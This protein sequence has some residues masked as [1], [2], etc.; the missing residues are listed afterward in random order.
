MQYNNNKLLTIIIPTY[1]RRDIVKENLDNTIPMVLRYKEYVSIYISDNDSPDGTEEMITPYLEKYSEILT[2]YKQ[3]KNITAHP[4]YFHAVN[5][6]ES[7]Y[8]YLL[9]DDDFLFPGFIPTIISLIKEN[10]DVGWFHFNYV[11]GKDNGKRC[12]LNKTELKWPFFKEYQKG[13]ELI[14]EHL[15][16]PSFM[17]SNVFKRSLWLEGFPLKLQE[18][19]CPGY[20]WLTV[21]YHGI[22]NSRSFYVSAPLLQAGM[23]SQT[24]Y[25]SKWVYYYSYGLG[26]LFNHFDSL[27]PGIYEHWLDYQQRKNCR[28]FLIDI[29]E[30]SF[31]KPYYK[32][33]KKEVL[34]HIQ[35]KYV[36]IYFLLCIYIVPKWFAKYIL[37]IIL[38]MLKLPT[39]I[40]RKLNH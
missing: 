16:S 25:A 22:L 36:K 21:L 8:C 37:L 14:Y 6:V 24:N 23:P 7:D 35:K 20:D 38:N 15:H 30:T 3:P 29:T 4:N 34:I 9:G 40:Y 12:E 11:L 13:A 39:L 26:Q 27:I 1:N 5:S 18:E 10:P 2:Y 31:N 17:S 19:M 28:K 32:E 33:R